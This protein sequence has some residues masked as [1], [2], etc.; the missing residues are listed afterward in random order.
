MKR[1]DVFSKVCTA[2]VIAGIVSVAGL[3]AADTEETVGFTAADDIVASIADVKLRLLLEEV[4]QRNP[5]LAR[6][7]AEAAAVE[8]RAP[9]VKALP[10]PTAT[11]TWFVLPPQTRVG[12]QRAAVN[13]TQQLPWFGTLKFDEQAALW[14]AVARRA[15]LEA[16]RINVVTEARA[17][18]HELQFLKVE[19]LVVEEDRATLEHYSELALA[20]R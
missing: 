15:V 4:L 9:Q 19:S 14:D 8:Q 1:T 11:L 7:T 2:L 17:D 16:A 18:Y 3:T 10:N 13:L 12:P 20:R 5:R 6:L